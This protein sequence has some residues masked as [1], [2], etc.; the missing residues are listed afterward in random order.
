MIPGKKVI[1]R[2]TATGFS[3]IEIAIVLVIVSLIVGGALAPLSGKIENSR[4]DYTTQTLDN[5]ATSLMGFA[6]STGRLPCPDIDADGIEDPVNGAGGCSDDEGTLPF[7]TLSMEVDDAWHQDIT[8]FVDEDYADDTDGTGC[9]TAV[10]G[11]SFEICS[12]GDITI[13]DAATSGNLIA[14]N[15]PVVLLSRGKHWT[16]DRSDDEREN[17]DND[18]DIVHR[19]YSGA[20]GAEYDDIVRWISAPF[21]TA[22]MVDSGA[23][24][25]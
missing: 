24:G 4:R 8:Y 9:G 1:F 14:Q 21:I 6:M 17:T 7:V 2:N 19:S 3:L 15:I 13:L 11:V 25:S 22:K 20:V 12:Q 5:A 16:D 23:L 10:P 18:R